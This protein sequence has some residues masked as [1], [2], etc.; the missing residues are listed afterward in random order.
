MST[1]VHSAARADISTVRTARASAPAPTR[2]P[3][4]GTPFIRLYARKRWRE[5]AGQDPVEAQR[6]ELLKL[7][8]AA[9]R[10]RFGIDHDFANITDVAEYQARV[11][12]RSY[13]QHWDEY[14]KDAFPN[15]VDCTWPGTMPYYAVS[16]GTSTGKVKYIPCSQQMVESNKKAALDIFVHHLRNRPDS[17][18]FDGK[19]FVLGG[20]TDLKQQAPGVYSGDISGIAAKNVPWWIRRWY[21]PPQE[22]TFITD[23]EE[24][25]ERLAPLALQED[26]R[27][28]SGAPGWL[29]LLFEKLASLKP[30]GQRR[31]ADIFPK[32]E[33]IT[34]GGV[35]MA[36]YRKRFEAMLQGS[37]AEM[38]EV[39]PAS[40]G[41]VA[42]ADRGPGEGLRLIADNGL[43]YE[44][45]P[46]DE[47]ARP[48][49]TRHWL[50]TVETGV[51]Y[52]IVLTTCAG[53]WSYVIGDVV[54]FVDR[55]PPRLLISGRTSYMLSSFG[56]HLTGELI[57][58]CVLK[59]AE[60]IG[61]DVSE[62]SVGTRYSEDG[63]ELGHHVYV[64]EFGSLGPEPARLQA[65]TAAVDEELARRNED[66]EERRVIA[67]GV[68]APEVHAVPPGTFAAWMKSQGKLGGQNKVPR[69]IGDQA[70]LAGL[71]GFIDGA[72]SRQA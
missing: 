63:R 13:G 20:S 64:V 27:F 28:I 33:L 7:V 58:T 49:A 23:W 46:V 68:G 10:T 69:V 67:A 45:V 15:L 56:E 42:I 47:I 9:A 24:K 59:A 11:P 50:G 61:A 44:F 8:Q 51:D 55:D 35:S 53:L 37:G 26:I 66:Y 17:R 65:F 29:T 18:V 12:L 48:N 43:F 38:R 54:R 6:R 22:L 39:Y 14:W 16:S 57:E 2:V 21:F 31:I 1:L 52:A 30:E 70:L 71:L 3:L 32:L 19:S 41:F 5:L 40:E 4:P 36:P 62:F 72:E 34:H 60:R 25:I